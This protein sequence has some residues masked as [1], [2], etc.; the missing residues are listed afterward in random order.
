M[1]LLIAGGT[2]FVGRA[3]AAEALARGHAVTLLHRG[4][5]Q[6]GLFR[7]AEHR[8]GDRDGDL[9]A[10]ADGAWD[11]TIDVTGYV[12]RHVRTLAEALGGRGGRHTFISSVSA[13]ADPPGP[14]IREDAPLRHGDD[15]GGSKAACEQLA[16]ELH[17]APLIVRPTYVIGPHDYTERF[18]TWVRRL[19]AGGVVEAPA[20]S[21]QPMQLVDARDLAA[22]ILDM[23]GESGPV[24]VAAPAP[25]YTLAD[26]LDDIARAVAPPGTTIRWVERA[27]DFPLAD[28]PDAWVLAVDP[29]RA[30]AHGFA[31]RPVGDSARDVV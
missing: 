22:L 28:G 8:I 29:A 19:A 6:P 1:R 16:A 13:Y 18:T 14:G 4:R 7:A 3:I 24:H 10:L 17:E 15:Y 25:P 11:A 30:Y 5:T 9:S 2:R 26:M 12:P 20:P 23:Q 31:P 21:E 27:G